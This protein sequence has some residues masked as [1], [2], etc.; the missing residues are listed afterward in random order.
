LLFEAS[1]VLLVGALAR[2]RTPSVSA[3]D[4]PSYGEARN[5]YDGTMLLV[6]CVI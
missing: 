3:A 1:E 5:V 2:A 4:A 6:K